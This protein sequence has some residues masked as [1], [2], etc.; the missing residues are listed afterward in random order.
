MA[1]ADRRLAIFAVVIFILAGLA[2]GEDHWNTP[3]NFL[4]HICF[5][6][7]PCFAVWFGRRLDNKLYAIGFAPL[8][9]L[10]AILPSFLIFSSG[11]YDEAPLIIG[12]MI[13]LPMV[14]AAVSRFLK[15][16][17]IAGEMNATPAELTAK[18]SKT[19]L[20]S[21][22]GF[23]VFPQLV[24]PALLDNSLRLEAMAK[25]LD[26]AEGIAR[27]AKI[28]RIITLISLTLIGI[29]GLLSVFVAITDALT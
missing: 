7:L 11:R 20:F 21:I 4:Q 15:Q 10:I 9:G 2:G 27:P 22:I 13:V 17:A 19:R 12:F 5:L 6:Y 8:L 3:N 25:G 18:S 14:I 1:T 28:A 23:V 26:D 29:A 16:R 24:Q